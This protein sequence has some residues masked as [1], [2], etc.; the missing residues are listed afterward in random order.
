MTPVNIWWSPSATRWA[1]DGEPGSVGRQAGD[2]HAH[3]ADEGLGLAVDVEQPGDDGAVVGRV[4]VVVR[5][6]RRGAA[7][8]RTAP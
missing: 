7:S 3:G 1:V 2:L 8:R 6:D 5:A 4:R